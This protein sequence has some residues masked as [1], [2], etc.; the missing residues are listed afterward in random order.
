MQWLKRA[1]KPCVRRA[2]ES[3]WAWPIIQP[4]ARTP[5]HFCRSPI[6]AC[7]AKNNAAK[8]QAPAVIPEYWFSQ[9]PPPIILME[10]E[11]DAWYCAFDRSPIASILDPRGVYLASSGGKMDY[12]CLYFV[13][14]LSG[15]ISVAHGQAAPNSTSAK[16]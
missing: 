6:N 10:A 2:S 3:A 13:L 16:T 15:L 14:G 8:P 4:T 1:T 11:F 12:R 5:R 7:T 9:L